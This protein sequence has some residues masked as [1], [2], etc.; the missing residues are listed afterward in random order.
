MLFLDA[1]W[2]TRNDCFQKD[3]QIVAAQVADHEGLESSFGLSVCR[4]TLYE[5]NDLYTSANEDAVSFPQSA[6]SG[7]EESLEGVL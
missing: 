3:G 2:R 6:P 1:P 4:S 7:K 5:G